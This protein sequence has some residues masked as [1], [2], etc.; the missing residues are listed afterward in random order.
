MKDLRFKWRSL[1]ASTIACLLCFT[2]AEAKKPS[3]PPGGGGGGGGNSD[4][5]NTLIIAQI[6]ASGSVEDINDWQEVVGA[7]LMESG[8]N[9]AAYWA[10]NES[11][12]EITSN[13]TILPDGKNA[14]AINNLGE[15]VGESID[16]AGNAVAVYWSSSSSSAI[17]LPALPDHVVSF[18]SSINND[19]LICGYVSKNALDEN[20]EPI[21]GTIDIPSNRAVV[22]RAAS[23]DGT[24]IISGPFELPSDGDGSSSAAH[25]VNDSDESGF[26]QIVGYR[27]STVPGEGG[28][29]LWEVQ[30][31]SDGTVSILTIPKGDGLPTG[32]NNSG[33]FCGRLIG[34]SEV[35]ALVWSDDT[36][37]VLDRGK[38][39]NKVPEAWAWD[40]GDTGIVVGMAGTYVDSRACLWDG[41]DGTLTYLDSYLEPDSPVLGLTRATAVNAS[42]DI[43]G[44]GP[45]GPFIAIQI[46]P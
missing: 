7:V 26:A 3:E 31:D 35:D 21:P 28:A 14:H 33:S 18:A 11:N 20:N 22:W 32:I 45:T 9:V 29:F 46:S 2:I 6:A 15:I 25:A 16:I 24:P 37:S 12:G 41:I 23:D 8:D 4:P 30:S 1:V 38:G 10:V 17:E 19:G 13:L 27:R 39:R 42:G 36:V 34:R 44:Q 43:V 5:G 40:I